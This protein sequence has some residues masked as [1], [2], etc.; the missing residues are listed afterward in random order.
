MTGIQRRIELDT[1]HIAKHLSNTSQMQRLLRKGL[2]AHVFK[3]NETLERVAQAIMENIQ[4][5]L[6]NMSDMDLIFTSAS[7]VLYQKSFF[8]KLNFI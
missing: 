4:V 2:A 1:R 8:L 6:E 3:D 7:I 5:K